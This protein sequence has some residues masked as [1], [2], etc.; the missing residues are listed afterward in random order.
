MRPL[1]L[2][3][4]GIKLSSIVPNQNQNMEEILKR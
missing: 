1:I 3:L 4:L 2:S